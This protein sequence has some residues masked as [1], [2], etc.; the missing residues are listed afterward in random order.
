MHTFDSDITI[1][2]SAPEDTPGVDATLTKPMWTT[3]ATPAGNL[4]ITVD[5]SDMAE[6]LTVHLKDFAATDLMDAIYRS[7]TLIEPTPKE[8]ARKKAKRK[9][10][11]KSRRRNR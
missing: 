11:K 10:A 1:S 2:S 6:G 7:K 8:R 9:Q 4:T 5:E 3:D